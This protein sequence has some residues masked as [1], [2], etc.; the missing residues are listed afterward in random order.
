V[1]VHQQQAIPAVAHIHR[2][3]NVAWQASDL[4]E[5]AQRV[6]DY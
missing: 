2:R 6:K 1:D 5:T 3:A 4:K